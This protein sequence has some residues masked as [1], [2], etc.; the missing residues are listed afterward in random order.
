VTPRT[1]SKW[2]AAAPVELRIAGSALR[3]L[4]LLAL[5]TLAVAWFTAGREGLNGALVGVG[6]VAG[7]FAVAAG[8]SALAAPHGPTAL[9]AAVVGGFAL[10]LGA[11]AGLIVW[12]RPVEAIHGPSLAISAALVLMS[13]LA[14][15]AWHVS[16]TPQFFW[17]DPSA[18]IRP[19]DRGPVPE[20]PLRAPAPERTSP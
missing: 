14:Y 16:R 12:L 1:P 15:E 20:L 4:A 13:T 8:L 9:F 19:P 7:M 5:P 11:Y 3:F 10:R 6:V 18:S 2:G 17:I